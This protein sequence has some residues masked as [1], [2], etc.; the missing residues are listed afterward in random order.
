M[1]AEVIAGLLDTEDDN[2]LYGEA[3]GKLSRWLAYELEEPRDNV[4]EPKTGENIWYGLPL[5]TSP[6][7]WLVVVLCSGTA[8]RKIDGGTN[9]ELPELR[10]W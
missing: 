7:L 2:G 5:L 8:C 9:V 10:G 4:P 6:A 1:T 3:G